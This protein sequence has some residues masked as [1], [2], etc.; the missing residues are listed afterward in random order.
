MDRYQELRAGVFNMT[1]ISARVD[2]NVALLTN[3]YPREFAKWRQLPRKF[4][5][6]ANGTYALTTAGGTYDTEVQ[7]KKEWFRARFDFLDTNLLDR[8]FLSSTGGL[9]SAGATHM[10]VVLL[11]VAGVITPSPDIV[12]QLL[13][14]VPLYSLFEIGIIVSARV[15]KQRLAR[16]Q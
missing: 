10:I 14:F 6:N 9:V 5:A 3:A 8:P 7:W 12:S 4:T 15:Q 16:M 11:I 1:N 13:V 2:Q